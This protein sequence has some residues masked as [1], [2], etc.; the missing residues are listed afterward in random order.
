MNI[1]ALPVVL[2]EADAFGFNTVIF[3]V[4]FTSLCLWWLSVELKLLRN[5]PL[6]GHS[7]IPQFS[8][9]SSKY[10]FSH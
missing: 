5:P 4:A 9:H 3:L 1:C 8:S 7:D 10:S 2:E 6:S